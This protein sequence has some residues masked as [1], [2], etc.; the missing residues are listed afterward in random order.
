LLCV[1]MDVVHCGTI[2][3]CVRRGEIVSRPKRIGE[4]NVTD[5]PNHAMQTTAGESMPRP[6]NG[7]GIC[8]MLRYI[9]VVAR[10]YG[11]ITLRYGH[12]SRP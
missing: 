4:N 3:L 6:Y 12:V 2:T 1:R 8:I 10:P 11:C 5:E 7:V 9:I